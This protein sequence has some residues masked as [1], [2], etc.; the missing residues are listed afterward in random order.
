MINSATMTVLALAHERL[1]D[2]W[3]ITKQAQ[4]RLNAEILAEYKARFPKRKEPL[5]HKAFEAVGEFGQARYTY[6][7]AVLT[8][9]YRLRDMR[10]ERVERALDWLAK[11]RQPCASEAPLV[12]E[13]SSYSSYRSQGYGCERYTRQ[14]A[15][16]AA[17]HCQML[18]VRAEVVDWTYSEPG[19]AEP[20]K[21]GYQ[22]LAYT[23]RAGI[24]ILKRKP[25]SIKDWLQDC[26]N[27]GVNPRVFNPFLPEGLEERLGVSFFP[28]GGTLVGG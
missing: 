2:T 20:Y 12:Y 5:R 7:K 13:Q 10:K 15:E 28:Q 24:E 14:A 25:V 26:W 19:Q 23:D 21:F 3:P 6:W 11:R 17:A 22:V 8:R 1:A 18:G 4:D 9:A 16:Q 27:R